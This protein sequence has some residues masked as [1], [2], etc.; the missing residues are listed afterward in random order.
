[1]CR[2]QSYLLAK[3]SR[4]RKLPDSLLGRLLGFGEDEAWLVAGPEW[5]EKRTETEKDGAI[6]A[7]ITNEIFEPTCFSTAT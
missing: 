4:R 5:I 7:S 3:G 6:V 2:V 1:M